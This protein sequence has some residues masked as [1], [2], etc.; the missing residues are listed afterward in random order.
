MTQFMKDQG[1]P[2]ERDMFKPDQTTVFSFPI[3]SPKGSI[4]RDELT[5]LDH[6]E[7]WRI[8]QDNWCEHKPSITVNLRD[9]EWME[10]GAWVY[11]NFDK[12]SGIAFLPYSDHSYQQAPYQECSEDVY[13]ALKEKSP[14]RIK[15]EDFKE[16]G[17]NTAASQTMAC[18]GDVCE[19]VD[20]T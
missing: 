3:K 9:H 4:T 10:A 5:A 11:E 2:F 13:N 14:A 12:I 16:T 8:I 6:L 7:L 15:W 20:I 18:T 17:D 1:V 19:I